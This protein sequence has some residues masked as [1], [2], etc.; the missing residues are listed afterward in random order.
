MTQERTASRIGSLAN[1]LAILGWAIDSRLALVGDLPSLERRAH[2]RQQAIVHWART[3][4]PVYRELYRGLPSRIERF[5]DLPPVTKP[6]L[7]A[8]FDGWL[9]DPAVTLADLRPWLSD[10]TTIGSLYRGRY[11]VY[12]TSGTTGEPAVL[13]QDHSALNLY[14]ASRVRMYPV[15]FDRTVLARLVRGRGRMAALLGTGRHYGGVVMAEWARRLH[16]LGRNLEVFSVSAL[17]GETVDGLTLGAADGKIIRVLPP[18]IG[19]EAEEVAGVRRRQ[20]VQ[21]GPRRSW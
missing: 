2:F 8:R 19:S 16:P 5:S 1:R 12:T 3:A 10:P 14:L 9:T 6:Q 21:V 4:S 15:I 18:A 13:V 17:L 20:I 11:L 7:M